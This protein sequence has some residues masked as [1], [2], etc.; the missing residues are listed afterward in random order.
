MNRFDPFFDGGVV[1]SE[2]LHAPAKLRNICA[3]S[4]VPFGT[5][6]GSPKAI[7][8]H[9]RRPLSVLLM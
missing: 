6:G 7:A 3:A 5:L 2:A 4:E 8:A 9:F 1:M